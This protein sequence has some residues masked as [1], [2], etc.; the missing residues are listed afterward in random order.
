[1]AKSKISDNLLTTYV[2]GCTEENDKLEVLQLLCKT[3]D[4]LLSLNCASVCMATF[5]A[6]ELEEFS[7]Y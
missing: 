1:M 4:L 6:E 5:E 2:E 3:P 7:A